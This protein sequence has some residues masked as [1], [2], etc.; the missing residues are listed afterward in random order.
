MKPV[1]LW[2]KYYSKEDIIDNKLYLHKYNLKVN[3]KLIH[4]VEKNEGSY[5]VNLCDPVDLRVINYSLY[6]TPEESLSYKFALANRRDFGNIPYITDKDYVVNSY[7]VDPREH[8]NWADKLEIEGR[9]LELSSGGAI[10]YI[11]TEDL[12][13]NPL[14]IIRIIQYMHEHIVYA[15]INRKIGVCHKCGYTGNIPLSKDERGNFIFTCPKCGNTDDNHMDITAR[16]CGYLG[17]ISAGNT[18]RGRLDDIYHRTIHTDC[19]EDL[20]VELN[21]INEDAKNN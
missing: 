14:S 17:K 13:K 12:S 4:Y 5:T 19:N 6:G 2:N 18:N 15:E 8:I 20:M 16:I 7:H 21:N 9:Y 1:D 11:E 3:G 10:S